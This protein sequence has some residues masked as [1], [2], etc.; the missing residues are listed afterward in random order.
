MLNLKFR[1]LIVGI[2][3]ALVLNLSGCSGGSTDVASS[4]E[5]QTSSEE[6]Q[7]SGTPATSI[8]EG[9]AYTFLPTSTGGSGGTLTYSITNKPSWTSF[10]SGTGA[11]GGI[12]GGIDV[13]TTTGIVISV[14]NGPENAALNA[15]NI[16][17]I[18]V[19]SGAATLSWTPPTENIDGSTMMPGDLAGYRVYY[20]TT[21]GFYPNSKTISNPGVSSDM[22]ENLSPGTWFF[23]VTAFNQSGLESDFSNMASKSIPST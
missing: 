19:G 9:L 15:F 13:G 18:A 11:L 6:L 8:T 10:D 23:V 2:S 3:A 14:S 4:E 7:I 21:A 5:L 17:V 20:G 22:L 16:D 1:C 12:P